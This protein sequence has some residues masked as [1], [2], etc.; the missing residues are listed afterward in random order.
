M[1]NT[2][3]DFLEKLRNHREGKI[4]A[5]MNNHPEIL[6][7]TLFDFGTIGIA[8]VYWKNQGWT[9]DWFDR[10]LEVIKWPELSC[11]DE[12]K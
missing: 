5:F 11:L 4:F 1:E 3:K 10:P 8:R 6:D 9:V 7:D 2:N 12:A